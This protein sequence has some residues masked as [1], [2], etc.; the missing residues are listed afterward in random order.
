MKVQLP[1]NWTAKPHQRGFF[2]YMEGGGKRYVGV[3][4]R[5]GGK[6][7]S[8]LNWTAEAAMKRVGTYWH[9]LPTLAQARKAVWDGINRDGTR[10]LDQVWPEVLRANVRIDEMKIELVNGSFWQCVGSDNYNALVGTNPVGVVFSEWSLTDPRAWDYVRPILAENGGWAVFIFTPRGKNHGWDIL[11]VAKQNKDWCWEVLDVETTGMVSRTVIEQ[12]RRSGMSEEMVRQEYFCS[13]EAPNTGSY[14]GRIIEE[15]QREGQITRVPYEP[16]LGVH[17]WWDL[18]MDDC[19]SIWFTQTAGFEQRIIDYYENSGEPLSHYAKVLADKPY[20]YAG[21]HLPHDVEVRELGTGRSRKEVLNN[22]GMAVQVV[23]KLEL[24][25]GIEATRT[26]LPNCWFDAEK[27]AY[28]LKALMVYHRK[29][30]EVKRAFATHPEH[31]WSSHAADAFRYFAVG[32]NA[33]RSHP[34]PQHARRR[35]GWMAA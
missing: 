24:G 16:S 34:Y 25:D 18:G 28:G 2:R 21:H 15:L 3:W 29:W 4:H 10:V 1:N 32:S 31:D 27:C 17:T 12:E 33:T 9:M 19:T 5:R 8:A 30:D 35:S 13:F 26:L 7:T 6:D 14:Y 23:P 20:A 11:E 22:L